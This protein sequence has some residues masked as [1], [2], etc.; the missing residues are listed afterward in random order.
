MGPVHRWAP[1]ST[2]TISVRLQTELIIEVS[3]IELER[4]AKQRDQTEEWGR[5]SGRTEETNK[6]YQTRW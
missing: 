6:K 4:E 1:V 5:D 2:V 3:S